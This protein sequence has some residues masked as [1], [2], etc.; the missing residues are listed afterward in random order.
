[1]FVG[2]YYRWCWHCTVNDYSFARVFSSGGVLCRD[3]GFSLHARGTNARFYW[4][5]MK[6][7]GV[8]IGR[9]GDGGRGGFSDFSLRTTKRQASTNPSAASS[10]SRQVR[11]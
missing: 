1:M 5:R 9:D 3:I 4:V 2:M 7:R 8:S 11:A 6:G 10:S